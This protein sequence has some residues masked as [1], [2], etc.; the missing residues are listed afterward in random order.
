MNRVMA[1]T[2]CSVTHYLL[3]DLLVISMPLRD[4]SY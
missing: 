3:V 2:Y 1:N 4:L